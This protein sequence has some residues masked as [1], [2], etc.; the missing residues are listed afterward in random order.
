MWLAIDWVRYLEKPCHGA[1]CRL[2]LK[3]LCSPAQK[4]PTTTAPNPLWCCSN[5][6]HGFHHS[7]ENNSRCLQ[8]VFACSGPNQAHLTNIFCMNV[9]SNMN[10]GNGIQLCIFLVGCHPSDSH[11]AIQFVDYRKW[12]V[13]VASLLAF[14]LNVYEPAFEKKILKMLKKCFGIFSSKSST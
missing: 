4:T 9:L 11:L 8:L 12:L 13:Y 5:E 2:T 7:R 3:N 6:G 1:I 10:T 14:E